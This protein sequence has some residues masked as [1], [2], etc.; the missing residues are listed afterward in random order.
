MILGL[1]LII[2]QAVGE[3]TIPQI[4]APIEESATQST[5]IPNSAVISLIVLLIVNAVAIFL[6]FTF[7]VA[8]SK[9]ENHNHKIRKIA[10]KSIVIEESVYSAFQIMST[11]Q[12]GDEHELLDA[13]LS[14]DQL[15]NK[16]KLYIG[17]KYYATAIKFLDY[18]IS[19]H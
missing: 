13:I 9:R 17:K 14:A 6:R 8:M 16:N 15:L 10:E 12:Q 11:F 2:L 7:D 18:Y 1:F 3:D 4:I 19:V 5:T